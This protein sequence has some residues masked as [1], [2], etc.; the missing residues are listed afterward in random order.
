LVNW[1]F[2]SNGAFQKRKNPQQ[3]S[4]FFLNDVLFSENTPPFSSQK[5]LPP[6][7]ASISCNPGSGFHWHG[8]WLTHS[9]STPSIFLSQL[10]LCSP[11]SPGSTSQVSFSLFSFSS[12]CSSCSQQLLFLFLF[13]LVLLSPSLVSNY[14]IFLSTKHRTYDFFWLNHYFSNRSIPLL[15]LLRFWVPELLSLTTCHIYYPDYYQEGLVIS[16]ETCAPYGFEDLLLFIA[17][18]VFHEFWVI[19]LIFQHLMCLYFIVLNILSSRQTQ[20][21]Y[22][23][24][25]ATI[26]DWQQWAPIQ[27]LFLIMISKMEIIF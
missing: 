18:C 7:A 9:H 6:L 8:L 22:R 26:Q 27:I 10:S 11:T 13:W 5:S 19:C 3:Q 4:L 1:S 23:Q 15:L 14:D 21:R 20:Y 17:N 12:F 25:R 16:W 2:C 24:I